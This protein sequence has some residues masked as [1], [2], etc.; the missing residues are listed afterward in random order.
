MTSSNF[1][2][3]EWLGLALEHLTQ[4]IWVATIF[5]LAAVCWPDGIFDVPLVQIP[6]STAIAAASSLFASVLGLTS[7][8][9]GVVVPS[10]RSSE[11][12]RSGPLE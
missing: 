5:T 1:S 4:L 11:Q 10:S 2:I 12:L 6:V 9:F 7:L 3:S 8:Y